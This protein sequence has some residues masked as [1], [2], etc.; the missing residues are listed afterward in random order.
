M[1]ADLQVSLTGAWAWS[2]RVGLDG[3]LGALESRGRLDA[4]RAMGSGAGK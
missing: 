1:A 4:E 3:Q 2:S